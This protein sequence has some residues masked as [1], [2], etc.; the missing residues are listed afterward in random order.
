MTF[1]ITERKKLEEERSK[2]SKLESL[3]LLA[4]GIAPN[5]KGE[6]L[7]VLIPR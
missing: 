3:G 2:Y 4:G 1:D 7:T 6:Y 5:V